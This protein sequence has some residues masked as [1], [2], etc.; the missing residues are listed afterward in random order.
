[1]GT[2]RKTDTAHRV[3]QTEVRR[4]VMAHL[5][6]L[7]TSEPVPFRERELARTLKVNRL[8]VRRAAEELV[9]QGILTRIP[10]RRGLFLDPD[11]RITHRSEKYYGIL[12]R[13]GEVPVL[14]L[15]G[16]RI[17]NGFLTHTGEEGYV[18]CQFLTLTGRTPERMA[19]EIMTWP[20][21]ALIWFSPSPDMF[22]VLELLQERSFPLA[23][24][25]SVSDPRIPLWRTN[26]ISL[27]YCAIGRLLAEKVLSSGARKLLFAGLRSETF[28]S[29]RRTLAEHHFP[30]T[31]RSF[32][33][34]AFESHD[35][36]K[37]ADRIR[38]GGIEL[39]VSDGVV[40]NDL[41]KLSGLTDFASLR[42]LLL[43]PFR[44]VKP[45]AASHPEYPLI[46]PDY[47]MDDNLER[48]GRTLAGMIAGP[49]PV[50]RFPNI[51]IP[52][53]NENGKETE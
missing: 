31:S 27:D 48:L 45:V 12:V 15:A 37:L 38:R 43:P 44:R 16:N 26:V 34:Y 9:R 19:D 13:S 23:V 4:Y 7:C 39:V 25:G 36:E 6:P 42:F 11:C 41:Q 47:D 32:L 30:F 14:S 20:L 18:D 24:V 28:E 51:V 1:M 8:T 35:P 17:L 5:M 46:F 50:L 33:D 49:S 22:P 21:H 40:F 3:T 10:G 29:F 53:R 2:P 52:I